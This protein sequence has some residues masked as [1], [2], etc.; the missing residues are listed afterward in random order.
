MAGG[1]EVLGAG[2]REEARVRRTM[3]AVA[4]EAAA[5]PVPLVLEEERP[6]LLRVA[7]HA[8]LPAE[9]LLPDP[10]CA[11]VRIVA[12]DAGDPALGEAVVGREP[13]L[14]DDGGMA[15]EATAPG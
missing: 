11:G 5:E 7:F 1:A 8:V 6:P 2:V 15:G 12:V 4:G 3:G 13:E 9:L 10:L 14:R